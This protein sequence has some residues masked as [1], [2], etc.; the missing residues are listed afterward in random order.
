MFHC[1]AYCVEENKHNDKPVEA[2]CFYGVTDPKPGSDTIRK[3]QTANYNFR[4]VICNY[5][6][7]GTENYEMWLQQYLKIPN[8]SNKFIA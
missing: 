1:S 2:L 6:S 3:S 4:N 5:V 8:Y 7:Y